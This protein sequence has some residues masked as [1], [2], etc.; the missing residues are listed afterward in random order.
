MTQQVELGASG[1]E[2]LA[3]ILKAAFDQASAGKGKERHANNLPF[4]DQPMQTIAAEHGIGFITGQARKK[5]EEALGM[6]QRGHADAAIK[7]LLG[8]IVYT[9]GAVIYI[10]DRKQLD[11]TEL[12]D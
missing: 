8:T 2:R 3:Q 4:H 10:E 11:P 1:Y 7:E 6:F 9:A 12:V 5:M